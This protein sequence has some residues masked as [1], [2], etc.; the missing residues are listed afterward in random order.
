ML[1]LAR[2]S[3]LA[4][5][6]ATVLS[7]GWFHG[8]SIGEYDFTSSFR[9]TWAVAYVVLLAAAAYVVGLPDLPRTGLQAVSSAGA[10]A[11]AAA[12]GVSLVQL[13]LGSQLLPRFVVFWSPIVLVPAWTGIATL[14]S[15]QRGRQGR[16]DRVLL[17]GSAEDG[18]R[19]SA[20]LDNDP[21]HPATVV[22]V[23]PVDEVPRRDLAATARSLEASVVVL[24]REALGEDDVIEAV[25]T[26]HEQGV[27]VR[28]LALFY[29]EWL[30][31]LPLS[32]LE[33]VALMFDIGEIHRARYGRLKRTLDL[34]VATLALP[35][36]VLAIPF[37]FTGNLVGGN[38]GPLFYWQRRVGR[39]NEEFTIWKFR[40][41]HC[42]AGAPSAWTIAD[43][44]RITRFGRILRKTHVDELPQ[45]INLF[46][47]DLTTVG[48]RPEQPSYVLELS[49]KIRFYRLRHLV[50]PGVTG[51]AQVKYDYGSTDIDAMEK[52]QYEF[53]YLRH[54]SLTLDLRI[55]GRTLRSI[56]LG[57]GR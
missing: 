35:V 22:G 31:K 27:R 37:V 39:N 46:K 26:L 54:Q 6:A 23:L 53:W 15:S 18:V 3:L 56:G 50:R 28:T 7:L 24:V 52:L 44:P 13:T 33:R 49:E 41:M 20:E 12:V 8:T 42:D 10:A 1:R 48:P 11:A 29:D 30:G 14:V 45:A 9:F 25:A 47:G 2:W 34:A 36:F 19:L 4:L 40:T 57:M 43:D 55:V 38:R 32:E 5:T 51:W 21:E 17:V 16:R